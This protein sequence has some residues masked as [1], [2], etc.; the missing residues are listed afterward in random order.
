MRNVEIL[1]IVD[2]T[3]DRKTMSIGVALRAVKLCKI[4][5]EVKIL[6]FWLYNSRTG[7]GKLLPE[8]APG[9]DF[10]LVEIDVSKL[11]MQL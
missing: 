7:V 1:Y 6:Y 3:G 9:K 11:L 2:V 8:L 4:G 10:E 5:A